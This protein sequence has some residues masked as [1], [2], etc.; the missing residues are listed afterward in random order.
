[1]LKA[2]ELNGGDLAPLLT[3]IQVSKLKE[4]VTWKVSKRNADGAIEELERRIEADNA[5][6]MAMNKDGTHA[7]LGLLYL[8]A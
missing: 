7:R 8:F 4:G 3:A 2:Y 5:P 6:A 1:M